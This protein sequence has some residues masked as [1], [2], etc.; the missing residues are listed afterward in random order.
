MLRYRLVC[1]I[2]DECWQNCL[3]SEEALTL[4]KAMKILLAFEEAE[5]EVN[6]LN[7]PKQVN[8]LHKATHGPQ[9]QTKPAH[10]TA[11]SIEG[12]AG[13][14]HLSKSASTT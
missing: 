9:N 12:S 5:C 11:I 8:A 6:A 2:T 14:C 4:E 13:G 7:E 1:G 10:S 3:P